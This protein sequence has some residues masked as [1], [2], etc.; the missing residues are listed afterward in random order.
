MPEPSAKSMDVRLHQVA[1]IV[2]AFGMLV[3]LIAAAI[4]WFGEGD[5]PKA[6]LKGTAFAAMAAFPVWRAC[7]RRVHATEPVA[8]TPGS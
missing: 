8:G 3:S 7:R 2:V 5:L 4:H 1:L 6:M